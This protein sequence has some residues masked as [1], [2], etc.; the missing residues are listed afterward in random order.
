LIL[1]LDTV[2]CHIDLVK[3]ALTPIKI[4]HDSVS[5]HLPHNTGY[6]FDTEKFFGIVGGAFQNGL[7]KTF[8]R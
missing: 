8:V 6:I 7:L 2:V 1:L 3:Q 4:G 5:V